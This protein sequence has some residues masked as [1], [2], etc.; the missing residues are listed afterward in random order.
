MPQVGMESADGG[1]ESPPSRHP[2]RSQRLLRR[3]QHQEVVPG[4]VRVFLAVKFLHWADGNISEQET[5]I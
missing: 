1:S 4:P 2:T 3:L 5:Q